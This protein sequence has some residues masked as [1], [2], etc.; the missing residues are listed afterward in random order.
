MSADSRPGTAVANGADAGVIHDIGYRAYTGLR[1][2]RGH[3][4]LALCWHS[5]RSAFGFGRGAK[6]KIISVITF[7]IMCLPAVVSAVVIA[8]SPGHA[9]PVIEGVV[10][11]P[12]PQVRHPDLVRVGERE[13]ERDLGGAEVLHHGAQ[14]AAYVQ[15]LRILRIFLHHPQVVVLWKIGADAGPS[16]RAGPRH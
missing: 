15:H 4:V 14:L 5:F 1:Y 12:E 7:G 3:I 6:A 10:E 13:R 9:R 8:L 2:G 11:E 16:P